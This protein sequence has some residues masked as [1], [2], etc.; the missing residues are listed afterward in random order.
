MQIKSTMKYHFTLV[1]MAIIKKSTNSKGGRGCGEKGTLFHCWW[2]CILIEPLQR[3]VWGF[4]KNLKIELPYDPAI[5]LLGIYSEKAII[6]KG[7]CTTMFIAA[8]FTI[9]R[10]CKQPKCPSTEKWIKKMW[11]IYTME[12]YSAIKRKDIGSFV[13]T[14]MDLETGIQSEVSQKGKKKYH[15]I[16]LICGIQEYDTDELICKAEI[17]TQTQRTN[18]WIP[19]WGRGWWDELGDWV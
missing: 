2:E 4:L 7:T 14:W 17:E 19:R 18:I 6:Q 1:R 3:T 8:L 13:E 9:A 15:I 12:Y 11:H 16:S 5:P 10:T